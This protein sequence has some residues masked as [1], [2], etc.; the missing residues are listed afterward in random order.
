MSSA[1]RLI[2]VYIDSA[3]EDTATYH[4]IKKHFSVVKNAHFR[5]E[6]FG[7]PDL[8]AGMDAQQEIRQAINEADIV[9]LL[10]SSDY[11]ASTSYSATKALLNEFNKEE[12]V[13]TLIRH[14][15]WEEDAFLV[16]NEINLLPNNR[17]PLDSLDEEPDEKAITKLIKALNRRVVKEEKTNS[18]LKQLVMD[19]RP[20]SIVFLLLISIT[21]FPITNKWFQTKETIAI[22]GKCDCLPDTYIWVEGNPDIKTILDSDKRFTMEVPTDIK[23]PFTLRYGQSCRKKIYKIETAKKELGL[24]IENNC[25]S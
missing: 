16:E 3:E 12:V 9:L 15:A 13:A 4:I 6:I 19:K 18:M 1:T 11:L 21:L 20:Y 7:R 2:K 25:C 22:K 24:I 5:Y 17:K 14:C 10:L 8:L 23:L